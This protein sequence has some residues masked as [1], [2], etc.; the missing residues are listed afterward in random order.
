MEESSITKLFKE[1]LPILVWLMSLNK[2]AVAVVGGI[3]G[4]VGLGWLISRALAKPT[5]Q[6]ALTSKPIPTMILVDDKQLVATPKT[7]TLTKGKHTFAAVP[8][9]PDLVLTYAFRSWTLN[10]QVASYSPTA[11]INIT[12]P[13]V[14]TANFLVSQSGIYP[15]IPA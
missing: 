2:K 4:L 9:S 15:I 10:G 14:V 8:K 13:A 3:A 7:I 5:V 1:E 11:Q 12:K 6:V